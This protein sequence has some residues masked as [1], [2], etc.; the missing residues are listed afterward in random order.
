MSSAFTATTA[1]GFNSNQRIWRSKPSLLIPC[2][3]EQSESSGDWSGLLAYQ[4]VH[5]QFHLEATTAVSHGDK[6]EN[7]TAANQTS[8]SSAVRISCSPVAAANSPATSPAT[9]RPPARQPLPS[10]RRVSS[11]LRQSSSPA[12]A[13]FSIGGRVLNKYRNCLLPSNV[14]ALI[15]TRNWLSGFELDDKD[16]DGDLEDVPVRVPTEFS[17]A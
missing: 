16:D 12:S 7:S 5:M 10:A 3:P 11:V 6:L 2:R 14:Q 13:A 17:E 8:P 15:C 4:K 1:V 9:G